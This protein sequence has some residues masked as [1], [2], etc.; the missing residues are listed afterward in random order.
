M[1]NKVVFYA[2]NVGFDAGKYT[3]FDLSDFSDDKTDELNNYSREIGWGENHKTFQDF[4]MPSNS[5]AIIPAIS[6]TH[7]IIVTYDKNFTMGG[8]VGPALCGWVK[9]DPIP[10]CIICDVLN[11]VTNTHLHIREDFAETFNGPRE[12]LV[13]YLTNHV[14]HKHAVILMILNHKAMVSNSTVT[15]F[16]GTDNKPFINK[17]RREKN[18]PPVYD[19]VTIEIAASQPKKEHQG[20][21][22]AS[23]ARH[24]RRGHFRKY[25]SG[26][27][28]WVKPT[29]VGSIERGLIVHDYIPEAA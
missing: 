29:W 10:M 16:R 23:P 20:G 26:K 13:D 9:N 11:P 5:C 18:K 22:H 7:Q 8:Y 3:W 12:K 1:N 6:A 14:L 19:W 15:A 27:I 21:T 4:L 24:E 25:P 2:A 17:K 28:S